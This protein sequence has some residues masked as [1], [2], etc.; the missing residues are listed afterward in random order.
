MNDVHVAEIAGGGK[1]GLI[2][3]IKAIEIDF[4]VEGKGFDQSEISTLGCFAELFRFILGEGTHVNGE[5]EK[6]E[7][8]RK[9]RRG[10]RRKRK[11]GRGKKR[12][13]MERKEE[14]KNG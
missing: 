13:G 7:L 5:E 11:E 2:E 1:G 10:R 8:R 12:G 4:W 14:R 6:E 3:G 9:R